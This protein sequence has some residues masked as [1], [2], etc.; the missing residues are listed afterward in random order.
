MLKGDFLARAGGECGFEVVRINTKGDFEFFGFGAEVGFG[1]AGVD[2]VS[3][4]EG[5]DCEKEE[6]AEEVARERR[7][8]TRKT[9]EWWARFFHRGAKRIDTDGVG[10]RRR[11]RRTRNI[12]KR[13]GDNAL[14]LH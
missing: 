8:R 14:H 9:E 11:I 3:G 10:T 5:R 1:V 7:E 13:V 4:G 6:N 2:R 12:K